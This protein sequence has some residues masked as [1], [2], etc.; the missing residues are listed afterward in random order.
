MDEKA[1]NYVILNEIARGGQGIVYKGMD[2]RLGRFVAIKKFIT[3]EVLSKEKILANLGE[4]KNCFH[5]ALPMILDIYS[6]GDEVCLVME[7]IKGMSLTEYVE[8]N[9]PL[10][11]PDAIKVTEK[12]GDVLSYLHSRKS[13]MIYSDL[14]P[15]NVLI[16][17]EKNIRLIDTGSIISLK[18]IRERKTS[19]G[20]MASPGFSSPEQMEG[21]AISPR[22]DI[23]SLGALLHF[24]LSGED[25][26]KPPYLRR[27]LKECNRS[28]PGYLVSAVEKCLDKDD[29][30][31]FPTVE[32]FIE[33]LK[34]P[35]RNYI[36]IIPGLSTP[37]KQEKMIFVSSGKRV[38][39]LALLTIVLI[40]C[41]MFSAKALMSKANE[42]LSKSVKVH[43]LEATDQAGNR[44]IIGTLKR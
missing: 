21:K 4:I 8:L 1:K 6:S 16:D 10:S 15:D 38:G 41:V 26:S 35:R 27:H 33:K 18:E 19:E 29:N 23:F 24:M 31:R 39:A 34:N 5:P 2:K 25:P 43:E 36:P 3:S 44:I 7:F 14:K 11:V 32:S 9:G 42:P 12:V 17:S 13:G 20:N 28:L 22:S 37:Y 30:K 40:T